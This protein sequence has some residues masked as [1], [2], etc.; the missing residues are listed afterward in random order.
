[1]ISPEAEQRLEKKW[2]WKCEGVEVE[3]GALMHSRL[4]CD[5]RG[6]REAIAG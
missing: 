1:L 3:M 5:A 4:D 2:D 6:G